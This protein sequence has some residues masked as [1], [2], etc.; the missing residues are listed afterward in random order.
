MSVLDLL[1]EVAADAPLLVLAED[2]QWLDRPTTEVLAFVAR[3]LQSDPVVLLA[4]AREGYPSPLMNAGL[5]EHRLG[6]LAPA[7]AATLLDTSAQQL[8]A[9]I[10]DRVL[11]AAAGNPLA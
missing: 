9:V 2:A 3:R 7:E 4:A 10:R 11:G 5:P 6:G 1:S 8:P